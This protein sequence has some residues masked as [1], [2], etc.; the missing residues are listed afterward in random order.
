VDKR[1]LKIFLGIWLKL[2][3][4]YLF[5]D[6]KVLLIKIIKEKWTKNY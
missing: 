4:K 5:K 6:Y 3:Q 2:E 1:E